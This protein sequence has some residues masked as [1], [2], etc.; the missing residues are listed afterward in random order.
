MDK[1]LKYKL[2]KTINSTHLKEFLNNGKINE[3]KLMSDNKLDKGIKLSNILKE[4]KK[5]FKS[6]YGEKLRKVLLFG[7]YARGDHQYGS[8][9]DLMVLVDL[10]ND[11]IKKHR[12]Q[13]LDLTT[14]ISIRYGIVI[15]VIENNYD[16]FYE[17]VDYLPFY[18][19][20]NNEGVDIYA[21]QN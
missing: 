19:N 2:Y 13:V 1:L 15:S 17:W 9:L 5:E 7:S 6:I 4:L 20:V 14:D 18:N 16:H 8:D 3:G 12:N 10:Q 11:E 21:G